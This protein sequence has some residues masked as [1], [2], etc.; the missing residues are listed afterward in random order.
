VK[1]YKWI[2]LTKMKG[3]DSIENEMNGRVY[4]GRLDFSVT[5]YSHFCVNVIK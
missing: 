5:D 1:A 3:R 2:G 4:T